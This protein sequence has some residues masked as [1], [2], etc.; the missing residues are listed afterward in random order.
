ME[1]FTSGTS[2]IS[3]ERFFSQLKESKITSIIDARLH[4]SSQ[5]AGYAKQDS[6]NYFSKVILN[7][8]YIHESQLCPKDFDLK[9]YRKGEIDWGTYEKFYEQLLVDRKLTHVIDFSRWGDRPLLLCSEEKADYCHRRVAAEFLLTHL[10][11][12]SGIKHL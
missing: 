4:P 5:L 11:N 3:A 9:A 8:P 7:I 6:L 12:V 1:I 2:G 10:Q